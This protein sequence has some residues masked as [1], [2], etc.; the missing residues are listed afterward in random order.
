[1][2]QLLKISNSANKQRALE[3]QQN[4]FNENFYKNIL[5]K[6]VNSLLKLQPIDHKKDL[7]QEKLEIELF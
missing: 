4:F 7:E 2:K 1:M 5:V 6:L 3:E